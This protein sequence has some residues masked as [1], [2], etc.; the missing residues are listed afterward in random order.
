MESILENN[1]KQTIS[2]SEEDIN[3][4]QGFILN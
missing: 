3:S 4:S 2:P 1:E